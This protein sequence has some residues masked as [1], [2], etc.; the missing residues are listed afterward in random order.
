MAF[1]DATPRASAAA[2]VNVGVSSPFFLSLLTVSLAGLAKAIFRA[3]V[4][5]FISAVNS[6]VIRPTTRNYAR[7]VPFKK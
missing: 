1:A 6:S 4:M 3:G 7:F 5:F 2:A